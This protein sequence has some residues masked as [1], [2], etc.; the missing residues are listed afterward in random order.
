MKKLVA[1]VVVS[2]MAVLA[3]AG[4]ASA[5]TKAAVEAYEARRIHGT[6]QE[7]L[8]SMTGRKIATA[9][10][11]VQGNSK[12]ALS[13]A[14]IYERAGR[15]DLAKSYRRR[16]AVKVSLSVTGGLLGLGG[17]VL[18]L[19]SG[20]R[21][22]L[23]GIT[24]GV[25]GAAIAGTGLAISLHPMGEAGLRN[26]VDLHNARVAR[27]V[28]LANPPAGA[29]ETAKVQIRISPMV[30]PNYAGVGVTMTY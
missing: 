15:A 21:A 29:V 12:V 27:E 20:G 7:T 5:Q 19:S 13:D 8:D 1:T 25:A 14:D 18:A 10:V 2:V 11:Y 16:M 24:M 17:T 4:S 22:Q 30:A 3:A 28:G 6:T 9:K 26:V 23:A